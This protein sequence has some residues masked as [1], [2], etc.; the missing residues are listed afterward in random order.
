MN[1]LT[2]KWTKNDR[3]IQNNKK[4][5]IFDHGNLSLIFFLIFMHNI[6][7]W[8]VVRVGRV[9]RNGKQKSGACLN[10]KFGNQRHQIPCLGHFCHQFYEEKKNHQKIGK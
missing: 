6:F 7:F 1:N 4:N 3:T 10:I 8:W 2:K 5:E 9:V